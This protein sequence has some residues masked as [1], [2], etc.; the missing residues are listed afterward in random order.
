MNELRVLCFDRARGRCEARFASDCTGRA[1]HAHHV[2]P[3]GRGGLDLLANLCAV[4]HVCH[5]SIHDHPAA[6]GEAGLLVS[7]FGP[8]SR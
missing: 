4:C 7:G 2:I 6:A 3:R 1:E 8:P 5:R